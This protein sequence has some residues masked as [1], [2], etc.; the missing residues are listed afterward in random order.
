MLHTGRD[1]RDDDLFSVEVALQRDEAVRAYV[2]TNI[3]ISAFLCS[4]LCCFRCLYFN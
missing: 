4:V 1:E 3:V 2:F